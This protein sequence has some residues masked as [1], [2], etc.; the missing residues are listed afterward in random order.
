MSIQSAAVRATENSADFFSSVFEPDVILP[1]Q[2]YEKG[3]TSF[4]IGMK[5]LMAAILSDG[6]EAYIGAQ[7]GYVSKRLAD[8]FLPE[9]IPSCPASEATE[10]VDNS[11]PNSLFGFDMVCQ[12]LG[13]APEYLKLGLR[14]YVTTLRSPRDGKKNGWKRIRRP[15]K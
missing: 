8:G 4:D 9:D 5:K 13:I 14:R 15:R 2:F 10:W 6:I 3:E 1:S 12:C 11:D 7:A